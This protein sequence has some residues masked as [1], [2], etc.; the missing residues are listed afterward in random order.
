MTTNL[1]VKAIEEP[2]DEIGLKHSLS[3]PLIRSNLVSGD[4]AFVQ[5]LHQTKKDLVS[6]IHKG[7]CTCVMLFLFFLS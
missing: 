5:I 2:E 1:E 6:G 4:G 7:P 3:R